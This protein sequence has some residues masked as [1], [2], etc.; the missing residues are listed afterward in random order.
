MADGVILKTKKGGDRMAAKKGTQKTTKQ[1]TKA[2]A[3]QQTQKV[4]KVSI[5]AKIDRLIDREGSNLKA[6]ASANI[7]GA[8]AVHGIKIT[9]SQKGLFVSMP[10][11][12][13]TDRDGNT[14]YNDIFHP[15]T[16]ESREE[17]I[18]KVK[19]AYDQALEESQNQGESEEE[20]EGLEEEPPQIGP[21]M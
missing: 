9:D 7:G 1:T 17:L 15:I 14:Q 6:I 12:S 4:N 2:P 5:D 19:E 16:A 10:S 3:K 11:T 21:T 8:F 20:S 18:N 13:Y